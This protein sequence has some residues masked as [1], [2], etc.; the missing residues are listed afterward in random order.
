[1]K[2]DNLQKKLMLYFFFE[3]SAKDYECI[4]K[5]FKTITE[6]YYKSKKININPDSKSKSNSVNN[7]NNNKISDSNKQ[8]DVIHLKKP[9]KKK[10]K[11]KKC[12]PLDLKK[13]IC[14]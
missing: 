3:T 11:N 2:D 6:E 9:E 10:E 14:S 4:E 13:I 8:T 12:F 1:M 7:S 5:V